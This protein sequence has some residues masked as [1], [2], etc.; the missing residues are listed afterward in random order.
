MVLLKQVYPLAG[1][2]V[3]GLVFSV[4]G[5][6]E[7]TVHR[8]GQSTAVITQSGSG[9]ATSEVIRTPGTR[10]VVTRSGSS[11]SVIMQSTDPAGSSR[12]TSSTDR[13][14]QDHLDMDA[15]FDEAAARFDAHP[16]PPET[17]SSRP[18]SSSSSSSAA[19]DFRSRL[20]D[21]I[22]PRS[23]DR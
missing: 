4:V 21:R 8:D 17:S 15:R 12:V 16:T 14:A 19:E 5:C 2:F 3:C 9:P 11:Q 1:V 13:G 10:T 23:T 6:A 7:T 18:D 20:M 22:R